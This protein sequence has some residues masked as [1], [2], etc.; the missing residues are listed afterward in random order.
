[1]RPSRLGT[2]VLAVALAAWLVLPSLAVA[3]QAAVPSNAPTAWWVPASNQLDTETRCA[4]YA[5]YDRLEQGFVNR[6]DP[7]LPNT[8]SPL[9]SD[10]AERWA[11]ARLD[12]LRGA[13]GS[14]L[15]DAWQW[16]A[17]HLVGATADNQ[18]I[19]LA[20]ELT[21][22]L[23][24]TGTSVSDRAEVAYRFTH[25][26]S[27]WQVGDARVFETTRHTLAPEAVQAVR[28]AF[29]AYL[30]RLVAVASGSSRDLD[31]LGAVM[32][33][34]ELAAQRQAIGDLWSAGK[35]T[36]L[37]PQLTV[38]VYDVGGD[39]AMVAA[40]G[41]VHLVDTDLA[42][43]EQVPDSARDVTW[44]QGYRLERQD[45]TWK[46]VYRGAFYSSADEQADCT[47]SDQ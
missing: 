42:S 1:M 41:P 32:A 36:R 27:G 13:L 37:E 18:P 11:H 34:D 46:V 39:Q 33:G 26:E 9:L 45:G 17:W 12:S 4:V 31:S 28:D 20:T 38:R 19:L 44:N 16:A 2:I 14:N 43:G 25:A 3:Q 47:S 29:G 6:L 8:L 30:D 7:S 35:A 40:E 21:L 23:D 24:G 10:A 5:A 22:L 15:H